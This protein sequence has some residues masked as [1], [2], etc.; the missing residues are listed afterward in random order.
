MSSLIRYIF[1]HIDTNHFFLANMSHYVLRI[2][3]KKNPCSALF[4]KCP[5]FQSCEIWG[6]EME[7]LF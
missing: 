7:E 2:K 4:K 5:L 1:I 6:G 3:K